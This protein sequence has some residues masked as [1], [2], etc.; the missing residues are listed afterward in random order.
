MRSYE[1]YFD[2]LPKPCSLAK[3]ISRLKNEPQ[4]TYDQ[5]R[6]KDAL[7]A[8]PLKY[9][10]AWLVNEAAYLPVCRRAVLRVRGEMADGF[11]VCPSERKRAS[12]AYPETRGIIFARD[13]LVV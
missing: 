9:L 7:A 6:G 12:L 3:I 11:V 2:S 8:Y 1:K 5:T 13:P 4:S 10:T